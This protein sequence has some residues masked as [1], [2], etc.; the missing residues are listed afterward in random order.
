MA[1]HA[2]KL[3]LSS[4]GLFTDVPSLRRKKLRNSVGS[5]LHRNLLSR[6]EENFYSLRFSDLAAH[7]RLTAKI[8]NAEDSGRCQSVCYCNNLKLNK[9]ITTKTLSKQSV[10]P[11]FYSAIGRFRWYCYVFWENRWNR[12]FGLWVN[13]ILFIRSSSEQFARGRVPFFISLNRLRILTE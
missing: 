11:T 12:C 8:R 13:V 2:W 5:A 1:T 9:T 3:G 10:N 4:T 7:S 6:R